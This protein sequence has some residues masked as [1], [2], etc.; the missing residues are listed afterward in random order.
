MAEFHQLM[1]LSR[2]TLRNTSRITT[3]MIS[4]KA[5]FI[6]KG[7]NTSKEMFRKNSSM[8]KIGTI[9][10]QNIPEEALSTKSAPGIFR[11]SL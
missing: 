2:L 10:P 5:M 7:K 11:I 9:M 3:G 6:G 4:A 8:R 1:N